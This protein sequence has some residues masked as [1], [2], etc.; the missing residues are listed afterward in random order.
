MYEVG[1]EYAVKVFQ[2]LAED[3]ESLVSR[4]GGLSIVAT[5]FKVAIDPR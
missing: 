5:V 3:G 1:F 4:R 2:A